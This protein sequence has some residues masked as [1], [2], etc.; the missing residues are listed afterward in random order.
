MVVFAGALTIITFS[1]CKKE[2]PADPIIAPSYPPAD[3]TQP[4]NL[5]LVANNWV[6]YE[7][8]IYINTFSG[9][10]AS[11]NVNGNRTVTVY[12]VEDGTET[13]ISQRHITYKGHD[14][15]ATSSGVDVS[16]V[17]H[18]STT[19]PFSSMNIRV[20]VK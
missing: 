2:Q 7:S 16:I 17:Y 5:Y 13:Q 3:A 6:N 9:V 1:S 14:L 18:C 11:A 4:V 12:V 20:E 15:S 10:L 8:E 19:L